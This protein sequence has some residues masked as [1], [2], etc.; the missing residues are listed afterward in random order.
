MLF[1]YMM[2]ANRW[3]KERRLGFWPRSLAWG[4]LQHFQG[5]TEASYSGEPKKVLLDFAGSSSLGQ[6]SYDEEEKE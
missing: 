3:I 6:T 2:N 5:A 4:M 1:P